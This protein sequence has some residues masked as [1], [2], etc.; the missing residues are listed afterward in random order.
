[1]DI[2]KEGQLLNV[3]GHIVEVCKS[4]NQSCMGCIAANKS[5]LCRKMPDCSTS[6]HFK[7]LNNFEIRK[8]K[9]AKRIIMKI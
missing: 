9:K 8:A 7:K 5:A 2:L 3:N 4:I 6:I 1:M